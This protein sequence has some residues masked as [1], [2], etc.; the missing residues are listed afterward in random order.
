MNIHNRRSIVKG[1]CFGMV[2]ILHS[3]FKLQFQ[4]Y[5]LSAIMVVKV[6][7]NT[8]CKMV[9][10]EAEFSQPKQNVKNQHQAHIEITFTTL[11][12]IKPSK[13]TFTTLTEGKPS[14]ITF[15][16]ITLSKIYFVHNKIIPFIHIFCIIFNTSNVT[17]P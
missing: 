6:C 7:I 14:K 2:P 9:V 15:T 10:E 16:I 11:T 13:I 12:K 8:M 1:R 4:R 17:Q 5:L 3:T